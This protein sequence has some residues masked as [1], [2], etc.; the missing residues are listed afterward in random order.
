[1]SMLS[2]RMSAL[3]KLV[4]TTDVLADVGC[5]HAFLPIALIQQHQIERAIAMDLRSGPLLHASENI[6]KAGLEQLITTRLSDGLEALQENEASEIVI[7]GMGG[8]LIR[9]ILAHDMEKARKADACILQPQSEVAEVRQFLDAWGFSFVQED[10]IYEEGKYYP[11]MKVSWNG[12]VEDEEMPSFH[13]KGGCLSELETVFGPL[14]IQQKHLVLLQM[15]LN[16]QSF[17][18]EIL[19]KLSKQEQAAHIK[20]RQIEIQEELRLIDIL[21]QEMGE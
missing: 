4:G 1:M 5:D 18:Q 14:L 7:A 13:E 9:K 12:L 2:E 8:S 19:V 21:L 16:Q 20:K 15:A 11:M 3:A 6:Q 10:M 17:Y